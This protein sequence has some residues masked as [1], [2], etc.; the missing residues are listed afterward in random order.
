[1]E[2]GAVRSVRRSASNIADYTCRLLQ[3]PTFFRNPLNIERVQGEDTPGWR[4]A[5][6]SVALP[7]GG[8]AAGDVR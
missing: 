5:P 7:G 8:R 4:R 3:I 6:D 1:M 2:K